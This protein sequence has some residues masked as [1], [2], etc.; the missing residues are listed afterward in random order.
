MVVWLGSV[1]VAQSCG[2][3]LPWDTA[4]RDGEPAV[5]PGV[6]LLLDFDGA[7]GCPAPVA[8]LALATDDGEPVEVT[9]ETWDARLVAV[10]PVAPLE[11]GYYALTIT[12][13][14]NATF[15]DSGTD[16]V[17]EVWFRVEPGEVP[18]AG[19]VEAFDPY[20]R[21]ACAPV[22]TS[23]TGVSGPRLGAE[24]VVEGGRGVLRTRVVTDGIPGGWQTQGLYDGR[25]PLS[26]LEPVTLG[27]LEL[28]LETELLDGALQRTEGPRQCFRPRAC[29][30]PAPPRR[31]CD[32]GPSAPGLGWLAGWLSVVAR[33]RR[34]GPG[35]LRG[36]PAR[37]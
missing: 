2:A 20:L 30:P 27:A 17:T 13:S 36:A 16:P 14:G 23:T 5:P 29:P 26:V 11:P 31:G 4:P 35:L 6:A 15:G 33:H 7:R 24:V 32:T 28:C 9:V 34:R 25:T 1:A 3:P 19:R 21:R 37:S 12:G 10:R 18:P 8:D 22:T